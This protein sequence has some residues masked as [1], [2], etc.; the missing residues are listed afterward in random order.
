MPSDTALAVYCQ[1]ATKSYGTGNARIM[2]LRGVNLEVR[3]GELLMLVGPSGCGKTTLISVM[4]G[5]LDQDEGTCLVFQ[6]NFKQMAQHDRTRYRGQTI[7]FV[8]Q[9]FNLIPALTIAENVAVPLLINGVHRRE[10]LLRASAMLERM[11]LGNRWHTLPTHLSGGQQQ[12]VATARALVHEPR[13][14]VCDEPTSALDAE[15]GQRVMDLLCSVALNSDRALVIVTHDTRIFHFADRIAR[16]DDGRIEKIVQTP[17][18]DPLLTTLITRAMAS[19]LELRLAVARVRE[20]RARRGVVAPDNQPQVAASGAYTRIR[21]STTTISSPTDPAG[22]SVE[23]LLER[24]S[25]LFQIGFDARWE[26]DLFGG[27]RRAIEAAQ[28]DI[29]VA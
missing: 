15:T 17:D 26:L 18:N 21:R 1:G 14:V 12:R 29:E 27:V 8:F 22:A 20:V 4:A 25:D 19:N 28:A 6:Q 10:A 11:G 2:A 9:S 5:I 13:L 24:D 3:T 23:N 7:G 16:M